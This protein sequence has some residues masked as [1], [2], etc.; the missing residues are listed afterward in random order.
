MRNRESPSVSQ[1][2]FDRSRKGDWLRAL[3]CHCGREEV[4]LL[5]GSLQFSPPVT[6]KEETQPFLL[7]FPCGVDGE[8]DDR[9]FY[10]PAVKCEIKASDNLFMLATIKMSNKK[11]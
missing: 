1:T 10:L 5:T 4:N 7:V 11:R 6:S 8:W 3:I 2:C 9:S